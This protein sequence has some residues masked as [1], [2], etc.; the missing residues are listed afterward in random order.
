[1]K[2]V[3]PWTAGMAVLLLIGVM[4]LNGCGSA[5]AQSGL[6]DPTED[7]S[8]HQD[9]VANLEKQLADHKAAL[10]KAEADARRSA[11]EAAR[12]RAEA[13]SASAKKNLTP[14]T[15]LL[16]PGAKAGQCYARVLVPPAEETYT[17]NVLVREAA[18]KIDVVPAD[19]E[20]GAE[21]VL[22]KEASQ[23]LEVIPAQYEWI[24]E[25]ILVKPERTELRV[26][27]AQFR[28]ET[29]EVLV[30][31]ARTY[32]KKGRGLIEKVD[33]TTGEIVCLVQE[34]AVYKT[35]S[36]QVLVKPET[37]EEIQ[38]PAEYETIRK[39]VLKKAATT[40]SAEIPAEYEEIKVLKQTKAPGQQKSTIPAE[41]RTVTKRRTVRDSYL[42]WRQVL[43]ETNMTTGT[44]SELQRALSAKGFDPG[45]IDG[46]YGPR[47]RG[48][49]TAFQKANN[50]PTGGLTLTTLE[51]LRVQ[52]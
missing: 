49:V 36:R 28:T 44:V 45:P 42:E 32:W 41:Y 25:R 14:G 10:A 18:E 51:K 48:A 17:E 46:I 29:E 1:M 27:P 35:V 47:T 30:Q 31:P 26:V 4:Y 38:I 3:S 5:T 13:A 19:Y 2:P 16:P 15:E 34:P 12:A 23:K 43:C 8:T 22:V 40:R 24:E 21:T 11:D 9:Q 7:M 6:A 33:N 52:P 20:W 50:L 39:M 37:V